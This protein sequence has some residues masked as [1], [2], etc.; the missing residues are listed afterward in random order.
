M[1]YSFLFI[2]LSSWLNPPEGSNR[3]TCMS[4]SSSFDLTSV[5]SR[6]RAS[7]TSL[8]FLGLPLLRGIFCQGDRAYIIFPSYENPFSLGSAWFDLVF[9][10]GKGITPFT[11]LGM[12]VLGDNNSQ[13]FWGLD[14]AILLL[15]MPFLMLRDHHGVTSVYPMHI[16][17]SRRTKWGGN[18]K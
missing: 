8:F 17:S 3:M 11:S 2:L 7:T 18:M 4:S 1:I 14:L 10:T 5:F 15:C 16:I 6:N 13:S 9:S 12:H